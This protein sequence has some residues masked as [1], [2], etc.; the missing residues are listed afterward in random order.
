MTLRRALACTALALAV[1]A[2]TGGAGYP[3]EARARF[4][5]SCRIGGGTQEQCR[6]VLDKV[7]QRYTYEEFQALE[8][9]IAGSDRPPSEYVQ[10]AQ[11]CA[12]QPQQQ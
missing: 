9:D 8:R 4:M 10:L 5:Q 6:C 7:Q 11:S 2:C 3:E 12:A 1:A